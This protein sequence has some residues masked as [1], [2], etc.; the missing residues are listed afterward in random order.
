MPRFELAIPRNT[1]IN[2][3]ISQIVQVGQSEF[4]TEIIEV[5]DGHAYLAGL[6]VIAGRAGIVVPTPDSN[7]AWLKGNGSRV[8][9]HQ[10][11]QLDGPQYVLEL[12]GYNLDDT[13]PHT[14]Y[15][16]FE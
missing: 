6:Q 12:K 9:Y 3:P 16:D 11:I 13:Y 14:F 10:H 1:P 7:T 8:V 4:N 5:P 15:M 2:K